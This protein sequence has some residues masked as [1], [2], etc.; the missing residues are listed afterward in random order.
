MFKAVSILMMVAI[1]AITGFQVFWL[2][3]NYFKEKRD[4]EFRGSVVFKETVRTLQ[5]KKLKLDKV[6]N[7]S[8][9]QLRV[10]ML[11]GS[12]LPFGHPAELANVLNDV[13]IRVTDS[14]DG[15]IFRNAPKT[16]LRREKRPKDS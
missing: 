4:L 13:T 7:D 12:S 3:E 10:E 14:L 2:R 11:E 16:M 9:G 1:L 5:A 15:K 8:T 6:F